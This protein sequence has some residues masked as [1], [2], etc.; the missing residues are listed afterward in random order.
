VGQVIDV[1]LKGHFGHAR[2]AA[3]S[4]ALKS[5]ERAAVTQDRQHRRVSESGPLRNAG[6]S[7]HGLGAR[8]RLSPR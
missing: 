7:Q 5:K 3:S 6:G 2:F 8:P 1:H 4:G